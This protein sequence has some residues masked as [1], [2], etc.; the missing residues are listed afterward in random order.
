MPFLIILA[1]TMRARILF[2]SYTMVLGTRTR[3]ATFRAHNRE[4]AIRI[5]KI[6]SPL[7]GI[8][9]PGDKVL[10]DREIWE[11]RAPSTPFTNPPKRPSSISSKVLATAATKG[12]GTIWGWINLDI[13][14]IVLEELKKLFGRLYRI[15]LGAKTWDWAASSNLLWVYWFEMAGHLKPACETYIPE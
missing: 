3:P 8:V 13:K 10:D 9:I 6:F 12:M 1:H 14:Q 11:V 5:E 2:Y 15:V 4:W 7:C